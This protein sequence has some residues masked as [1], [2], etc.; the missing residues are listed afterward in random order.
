M[1]AVTYIPGPESLL[2]PAA[3]EISD[4]IVK[5]LQPDRE[6]Q[7][8]LRQ[9][10]ATKPELIQDLADLEFNAPG[11]LERLGFGPVGE[12]VAGVQPRPETEARRGSRED[13]VGLL[14]EQLG[15]QRGQVQLDR[16]VLDE[17]IG[18]IGSGDQTRIDAG[19]KL[20][21]GQT[22]A[23]R[24]TTE[25]QAT[26]AETQAEIAPEVAAAQRTA[27]Q[28][29]QREDQFVLN[30][31][32]LDAPVDVLSIARDLRAG[33]VTDPNLIAQ[34]F[35]APGM[36]VMLSQAF[37][38]V[39]LEMVHAQ[40]VQMEAMRS[41][42]EATTNLR[43]QTAFNLLNQTKTGTIQAWEAVLFDPAVRD[44]MPEL[45]AKD[46]VELT[47]EERDLIAVDQANKRLGIQTRMAETARFNSQILD[48]HSRIKMAEGSVQGLKQAEAD[49]LV[50][51]LN[52]I[53]K[54][55]ALVTGQEFRANW[56]KIPESGTIFGLGA[57]E[58]LYYTDAQGRPIP[59]SIALSGAAM[60]TLSADAA[61]ALVQ[62]ESIRD[63]Q[64][65]R[66]ALENLRKVNSEVAAEVEQQLGI[67]GP[68]IPPEVRGG[69]TR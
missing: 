41:G 43:V 46:P 39:E 17:A 6:F 16:A 23:Q 26:V 69:P 1:F 15:L 61:R 63:P 2:A 42:R 51:Q 67:S 59:E 9:T 3:R 37:R 27:A 62:I 31:P 22:E 29:Q 49:L 33:R 20:L 57:R 54:D 64:Q 19:L 5:F 13:I 55:R 56:G 60:P 40:Q 25:A 8:Q 34:I 65:R 30:L 50:N 21:T 68:T 14:Q 53:L 66:Q 32:E 52:E 24:R 12:T 47:R 18:L 38:Q 48:V 7:D 11:T 4:A 45:Y 36:D 44:M 10:I 58:G 28:R 35:A